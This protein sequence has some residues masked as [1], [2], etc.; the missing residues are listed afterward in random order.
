[1]TTFSVD[2]SRCNFC[3]MCVDECSPRLI[4]MDAPDSLPRRIEGGDELCNRCGHCV[5]VCPEAA[6]SIDIMKPEQCAPVDRELLP[7]VERVEHFLKSRR[8]IRSYKAKRVPSETLARLIGVARYAP[9]GHNWQPVNWLVV[10]KPDE[11]RRLG[12]M[13]V[14]WMCSIVESRP[15][16]AKSMHFDRIVANSDRGIDMILRGAPH[17]IVAHC[18]KQYGALGPSACIIAA[19]YLELAAY[20]MGLGACWAGYFQV[21]A[22]AYKP[23]AEAL[24]LPENHQV[25]A[26]LMVGYPKH[27]FSRIPLRN[28][29]VVTWR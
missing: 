1:M 8:S 25:H 24:A 23:L 11:T 7:F 14:E 13:V 17:V 28:Q 5:A 19:T 6:V 21:A 15:E 2:A 29:P 12:G 3:G 9:S 27:R 20:G 10:E 4:V 18:D 26:A 16:I 22:S